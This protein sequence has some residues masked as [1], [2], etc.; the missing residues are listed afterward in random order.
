MYSDKGLGGALTCV[1]VT[2]IMGYSD[3][4][5]P[6]PCPSSLPTNPPVAAGPQALN[7]NISSG[8][9]TTTMT[10]SAAAPDT[11]PTQKEHNDKTSFLPP[12][13]HDES[14]DQ[15]TTG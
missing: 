13:V 15:Q 7:T 10:P 11:A 8:G 9:G 3:Y 12:C 6:L 14:T 2:F 5:I 4:G 1:G